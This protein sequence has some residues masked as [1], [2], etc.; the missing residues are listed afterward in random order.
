V[1]ELEPLILAVLVAEAAMAV[2][3]A[4]Q[5]QVQIR[6]YLVAVGHLVHRGLSAVPEVVVAMVVGV[7]L[8][9]D[10]CS[11]HRRLYRRPVRTLPVLFLE[12]LKLSFLG[13]APLLCRRKL[14]PERKVLRKFFS[15]FLHLFVG[16]NF[17]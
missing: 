10:C 5:Y 15:C 11:L 14:R 12:T 2:P 8:V 1:L 16:Q 17:L 6:L 4:S 9:S 7:V 13:F 3:L